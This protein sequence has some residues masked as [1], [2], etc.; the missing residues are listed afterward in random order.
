VQVV[1]ELGKILIKFEQIVRYVSEMKL[2][3]EVE[4]LSVQ[5]R[6][7]THLDTVDIMVRRG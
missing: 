2:I 5:N 1:D 7:S 6:I 4:T 3:K